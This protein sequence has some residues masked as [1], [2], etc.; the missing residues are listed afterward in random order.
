MNI[1]S[2]ITAL[3]P[4]TSVQPQE[5]RYEPVFRALA[6]VDLG[7]W[8]PVKFPSEGEAKRA[9]GCL[10]TLAQATRRA[11]RYGFTLYPRTSRLASL[12]IVRG[13]DT[14]YLRRVEVKP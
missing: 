1:L 4:Q 9:T 3:P 7:Q 5:S 2:P 14:V 13:G 10:R 8:L 11:R 6:K 12:E